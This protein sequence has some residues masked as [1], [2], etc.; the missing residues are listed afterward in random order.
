MNTANTVLPI[1]EEELQVGKRRIESE[2]IQVR[3]LTDLAEELVRQ[4]LTGEHLEVERVPI[5]LLLEPGSDLP[6]IRT[7]GSVTI[8]PVLE[9]VVVVEKRLRLK[10]EVRI[11]KRV[12]D[13]GS[14]DE[15]R[16][17]RRSAATMAI[18][19][20]NR[21]SGVQISHPAPRAPRSCSV[22]AKAASLPSTSTGMRLQNV[23][24]LQ[25]KGDA[26]ASHRRSVTWHS[27]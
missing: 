1:V 3:T 6:R 15:I 23:G 10:E 21:W 8:F 13:Q 25:L 20:V 4:E 17:S 2:R 9:E 22:V 5:D 16:I 27:A 11:T 19:F 7:E 24:A 14:A 18:E 26:G 12:R